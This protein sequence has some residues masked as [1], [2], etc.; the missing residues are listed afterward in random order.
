MNMVGMPWIALASLQ[1]H[2]CP[3]FAWFLYGC[4]EREHVLNVTAFADWWMQEILPGTGR[5][6]SSTADGVNQHGHRAVPAVPAV[7]VSPGRIAARAESASR[8]AM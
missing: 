7:R 3:Q 2:R 8:S 6:R 4:I 1:P 5:F